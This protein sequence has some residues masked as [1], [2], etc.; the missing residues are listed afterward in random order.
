MAANQFE[1]VRGT[2]ATLGTT[3]VFYDRNNSGVFYDPDGSG[4]LAATRFATT[5][6]RLLNT[7]FTIV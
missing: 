5:A 4:P 6:V 1:Q 7:D 3:R 2:G